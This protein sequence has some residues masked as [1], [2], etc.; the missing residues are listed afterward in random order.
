MFFDEIRPY[1]VWIGY[2]MTQKKLSG[3]CWK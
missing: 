2:L 3:R 1:S